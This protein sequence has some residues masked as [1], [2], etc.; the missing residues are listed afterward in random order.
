VDFFINLPVGA[1]ALA[2]LSR[3]ERSARHRAPFDW[4]GQATAILAMG[5]LTYGAIEP[6]PPGSPHPACWPRSQ[7]R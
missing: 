2:L 3:T 1:V 5:G 4:I 7:S 6:E